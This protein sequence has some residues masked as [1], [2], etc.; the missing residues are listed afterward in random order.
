M[1]RF[2]HCSEHQYF[3]LSSASRLLPNVPEYALVFVEIVRSAF[4]ANMGIALLK[5]CDLFFPD[6]PKPL[7]QIPAALSSELTCKR[8]LSLACDAEYLEKRLEVS[9]HSDGLGRQYE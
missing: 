2:D 7:K 6:T 5:V 9:L 3:R 8:G 1:G 4:Y